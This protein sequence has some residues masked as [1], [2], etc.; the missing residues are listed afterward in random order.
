MKFLLICQLI[1]VTNSFYIELFLFCYITDNKRESVTRHHWCF[2][3]ATKIWTVV[4]LM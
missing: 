1:I 3:K 2:Y 4:Y